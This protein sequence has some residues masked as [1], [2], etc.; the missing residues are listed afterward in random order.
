MSTELENAK[1]E[2]YVF[3]YDG[4]CLSKVITYRS[5]LIK[6]IQAHSGSKN[7]ES[8]KNFSTKSVTSERF[9]TFIE[10]ARNAGFTVYQVRKL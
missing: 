8:I 1:N 2:K 9:E 3:Q 4:G 5:N 7:N 6:S 10:I